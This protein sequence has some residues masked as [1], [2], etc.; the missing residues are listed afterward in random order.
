MKRIFVCACFLALLMM[1]SGCAKNSADENEFTEAAAEAEVYVAGDD[2]LDLCIYNTDTLNPLT[3]S[4]K[5][6]AEVLSILYDSLFTIGSDF[7]AVPNLCDRYSLSD[8][9][10]TF[11]ATLRPNIRF[12]DGRLLSA[13]DVAASVNTILSSKGYYKQRLSIIKGATAKKGEVQIFLSAPTENLCMLLDFPVLPK[14]GAESADTGGVLS[15]VAPGSGLF[16]LSEY[17]TNKELRLCVNKQ[18]HSG[19]MPYFEEVVIHMAETRET[20]VS[21][22][23]NG[24]IDMLT[25]YAAELDTYTPPKK[26]HTSSYPAC[27]FVFLGMHTKETAINTPDIRNAISAAIDRGGILEIAGISG[28][29]AYLPIHPAASGDNER[30]NS[31]TPSGAAGLLAASGWSDTDGNGVLDKTIS[32]KKQ[33]LAFS[34]L[35]SANTPA[36]RLLAEKIQKDLSAIG[37]RAELE[38][39]PYETYQSRIA[40]GEYELFLGTAELL[41]DFDFKNLL[42]LIPDSKETLKVPA[43]SDFPRI[44]GE[45]SPLTG[46]YFKDEMLLYDEYIDASAISTLNPYKSVHSF[47]LKNDK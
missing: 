14:G 41:P 6:N 3:T 21:M 11:T 13:E 19:V 33:E 24:S 20:A 16:S 10:L 17:L 39:V 18:H 4:V 26:L 36:G 42:S 2:I 30:T 34:V 28:T 23:E 7:S 31:V 47:R 22:L 12:Q 40:K 9:G 15:T 8:N 27:K 45:I 29:A 46:L 1:F 38:I 35:V 43:E 5:H 44:F 37:I 32:S 25:G